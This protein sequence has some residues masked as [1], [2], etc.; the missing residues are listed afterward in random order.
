MGNLTQAIEQNYL[1]CNITFKQ[2]DK[3]KVNKTVKEFQIHFHI[4]LY[5]FSDNTIIILISEQIVTKV[6]SK[7]LSIIVKI[8]LPVYICINKFLHI[9]S[10]IINSQSN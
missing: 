10:T 2:N 5:N 8:Y 4:A 6:N 3:L 1:K 7:T 9:D